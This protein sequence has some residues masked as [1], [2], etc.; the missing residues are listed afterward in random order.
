MFHGFCLNE[1]CLYDL[2][3][4]L[5][6]DHKLF[7]DSFTIFLPN[8]ASSTKSRGTAVLIAVS[9]R[10]R[11][12]KNKYELRFYDKC[13]WLEIST[14]VDAVYLLVIAIPPDTKLAVISEY[15]CTLEKNL[16]T[17]NHSALLIGDLNFSN[18][19]WERVIFSK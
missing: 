10:V 5:C 4:D 12:F 18:F 19:D 13:V 17:K 8:R 6:F 9:S 14:Q 3:Y 2:C 15:F 16:S 1:T 11:T 7:P